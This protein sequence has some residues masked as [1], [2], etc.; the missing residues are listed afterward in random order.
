M[1]QFT[2]DFDESFGQ[3]GDPLPKK[4][5][6][7]KKEKEKRRQEA[8][9]KEDLARRKYSLSEKERQ[10]MWS[11]ERS[12][13]F[14]L[15]TDGQLKKG[16]SLLLGVAEQHFELDDIDL[17]Y[18]QEKRTPVGHLVFQL[19]YF[20]SKDPVANVTFEVGGQSVKWNEKVWAF[21]NTD[22]VR[23]FPYFE[24]EE[25]MWTKQATV[26]VNEKDEKK[27][28]EK[29]EKKEKEKDNEK[30][31]KKEKK[32]KEKKE[33]EKEEE[34]CVKYET[35]LLPFADSPE[36]IMFSMNANDHNF[37]IQIFSSIKA[38]EE[39]TLKLR[40]NRV[41]VYLD[42]CRNVPKMDFF[43][44]SDPYVIM[45]LGEPE[46]SGGSHI[47]SRIKRAVLKEKKAT[48]N[49]VERW[50]TFLDEP[51]PV[52]RSARDL[53]ERHDE[54]ESLHIE[55]WDEDESSPD[56]RIGVLNVPVKDVQ[57]LPNHTKLDIVSFKKGK[58]KLT[59][60]IKI[61]LIPPLLYAPRKTIYFIRHGQSVWNKAQADK[62]ARGMMSQVDHPLDQTGVNQALGLQK[63]I[64]DGGPDADELLSVEGIISSPLTRAF[65]TCMIAA[66]PVT[67]T[68]K[69]IFL[70]PSCREKRNLGGRDSAGD[71]IGQEIL[72]KAKTNCV[73]HLGQET[74]NT[75]F[76]NYKY[77]FA[78]VEKKW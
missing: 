38:W 49:V 3:V 63:K 41:I 51:D 47:G 58:E 10:Q 24:K 61:S 65:Q 1:A 33:K 21:S 39:N 52:W 7:S 36:P 13:D 74:A 37:Q 30:D 23:F 31:E 34:D 35:S 22:S 43:D 6:K 64:L 46:Y 9:Q 72:I 57:I 73:E 67:K 12:Q 56:D 8:Q 26:I 78:E 71:C 68:G 14:L 40:G 75:I 69:T 45:S 28:K 66:H 50:P 11:R 29:K 54:N 77:D 17:D 60:D 27:E 70:Q 16:E 53:G 2:Q 5:G 55:L 32:E 4:T 25:E 19:K 48:L 18:L 20:S 44:E 59:C 15:T 76:D 42:S 62:D